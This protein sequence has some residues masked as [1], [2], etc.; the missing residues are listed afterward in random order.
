MKD[1]LITLLYAIAGVFFIYFTSKF[2]EVNLGSDLKEFMNIF[3]LVTLGFL[4]PGSVNGIRWMNISL[5][6]LTLIYVG[7]L[8]RYY[9]GTYSYSISPEVLMFYMLSS[10]LFGVTVYYFYKNIN[11]KK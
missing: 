11:F 7:V 5:S 3:F 9:Y 1:K 8:W 4:I 6:I 2:F 10:F